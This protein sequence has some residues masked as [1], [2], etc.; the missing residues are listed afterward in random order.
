MYIDLRMVQ[1]KGAK[2]V[3]FHYI[4]VVSTIMQMKFLAKLRQYFS[5][6]KN[7]RK[8]HLR[9]LTVCRLSLL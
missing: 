1:I 6:N 8:S 5:A 2:E 4:G 3:L 7:I 9:K